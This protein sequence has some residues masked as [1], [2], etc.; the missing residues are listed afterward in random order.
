MTKWDKLD[1]FSSVKIWGI[2]ELNWN[3]SSI[4]LS[5]LVYIVTKL[6]KWFKFMYNISVTFIRVIIDID[7]DRLTWTNLFRLNNLKIN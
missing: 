1:H 3:L 4:N 5:L 6:I 2:W 7:L